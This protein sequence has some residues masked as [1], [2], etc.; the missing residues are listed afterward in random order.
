MTQTEG[1]V[2]CICLWHT[3]YPDERVIGRVHCPAHPNDDRDESRYD[4]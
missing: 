3:A 4:D 1:Y 2:K